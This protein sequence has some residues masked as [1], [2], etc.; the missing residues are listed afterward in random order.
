M[1]QGHWVNG[2]RVG[3]LVYRKFSPTLSIWKGH[4]QYRRDAL[5]GTLDENARANTVICTMHMRT[6]AF[7]IYSRLISAA[8]LYLV[9]F[10]SYVFGCV[11]QSL[12]L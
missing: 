5:V 7:R 2:P 8:I 10:S 11:C 1:V 12:L 4:D 3:S 9:T 6:F